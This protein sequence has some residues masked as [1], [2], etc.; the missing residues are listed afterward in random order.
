[1]ALSL[2]GGFKWLTWQRAVCELRL[3]R[4]PLAR[5]L[6]YLF[7]WPGMNATRF[8]SA[9]KVERPNGVEWLRGVRN[10]LT[11]TALVWLIAGRFLPRQ[12]CA[13][14]WAGLVGIGLWL[15]FGILQLLSLAWQRAGVY[16]T[17]IMQRPASATS[18]ADFWGRRWNTAFRDLAY[19]LIFR[20]L[21][22][23]W[24]ARRAMTAAF[25]FSGVLHDLAISVPARAGYGL[26]TLYFLLQAI[27]VEIE[28]S[29]LGRR[30]HLRGGVR[31]WM[32]AATMI[33][34]P[35]SLLFHAA[36][37]RRVVIPFLNVLGA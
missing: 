36:F 22:R 9:A 35:A 23:R 19:Q 31:G 13:A 16:A 2:Y 4:P 32:F 14:G 27:G 21:A 30:W 17:P 18:L 26:P 7:L 34:A 37:L 33:L 3:M 29:A 24:G 8:L 20:P 10:V 6:A 28:R 1:M 15:H 11:G 25:L 5:S 12:P